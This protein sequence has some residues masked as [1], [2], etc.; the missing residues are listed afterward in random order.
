MNFGKIFGKKE[1]APGGIK[2]MDIKSMINRET[3]LRSVEEVV[4]PEEG[5][6]TFIVAEPIRLMGSEYRDF[7]KGEEIIGFNK[8][9]EIT[10]YELGPHSDLLRIEVHNREHPYISPFY[11]FHKSVV[12]DRKI[13]I[14][15]G[16][17][18]KFS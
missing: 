3:D 4:H 15:T 7:S 11:F 1:E 12:L 9:D 18:P 13:K 6:R 10:V 2:E 17:K 16:V 14:D 8:G 5:K